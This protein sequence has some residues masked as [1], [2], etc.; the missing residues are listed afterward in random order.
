MKYLGILISAS[1]LTKLDCS[2]LVEKIT[3]RVH[4]WAT[5]NLSFAGRPTL[6]NSVIFGMFNYWA[7]I[8]LLPQNMLEKITAV[9]RKYLWGGRDE[10][11]RLRT[12]PRK[13][14]V[15]ARKWEVSGLKT[16]RPGIK[17]LLLNLFGPLSLRKTLYG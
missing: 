12:S 5:R 7:S 8:F 9:S 1:R 2:T 3:S 17:P 13:A 14:H 15:E 4:I 10:Y 6:I 16:L 11:V